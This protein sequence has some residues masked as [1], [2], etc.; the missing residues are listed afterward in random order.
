MGRILTRHQ[1]AKIQ[2]ADRPIS[3][4]GSKEFFVPADVLGSYPRPFYN[5]AGTLL[6]MNLFQENVEG[7]TMK[8]LSPY[9][10]DGT[11]TNSPVASSESLWRESMRFDKTAH[12]CIILPASNTVVQ[13]TSITME[14][15]AMTAVADVGNARILTFHWSSGYGSGATLSIDQATQKWQTYVNDGNGG[16]GSIDAAAAHTPMQ[17]TYVVMTNDGTTHKL[18]VNGVYEGQQSLG[19]QLGTQLGYIGAFGD[20]STLYVMDGW[21][22]GV[23]VTNR[24][25]TAGE[26]EDYYYGVNGL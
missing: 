1:L 20:G 15:W 3:R 19:F 16:T 5:E 7:T 6:C 9:G 13:G 26:I 22:A 21:I 14:G 23:R 10:R 11:I 25:K 17:W 24:A 18:Y 12:K 4:M 8:D 2:R